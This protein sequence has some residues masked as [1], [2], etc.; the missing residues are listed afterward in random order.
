MGSKELRSKVLITF[1]TN[2]EHLLFNILSFMKQFIFKA[3]FPLRSDEAVNAQYFYK[4]NPSSTL[5]IRNTE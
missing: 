4:S 1:G 2:L 5:I 3:Q